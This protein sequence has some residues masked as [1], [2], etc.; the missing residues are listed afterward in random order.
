MTDLRPAWSRLGFSFGGEVAS[1]ASNLEAILV[2]S[3]Q[4]AR[5]DSRLFLGAATWLHSY[6]FLVDGY[7]LVRRMG[8]TFSPP[9]SSL[10]AVLVSASSSPHLKGLLAHCEALPEEEILFDVMQQNEILRTKVTSSA[11]PRIRQ[12]G[13]LVDDLELKPDSLRPISWVLRMN[14]E[15]RIRALLGA[16]LRAAVLNRLLTGPPPSSLSSL[17]R[18][19]D[20]SYPSVHAATGALLA[21]GLIHRETSGRAIRIHVP[22]EIS[23]WLSSY[24]ASVA[25]ENRKGAAA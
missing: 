25:P 1:S 15:L 8:K 18:E 4:Q 22:S 5:G 10:L 6:G 2:A 17:A 20:R 3:L 21:A 13:L 11:I 9:H 23:D 12:W 24:P 19:L 14:P 7:D 16:N